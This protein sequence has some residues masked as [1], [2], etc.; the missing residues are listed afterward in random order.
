MGI[1]RSSVIYFKQWFRNNAWGVLLT[2]SI[3]TAGMAGAF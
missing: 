3:I 2:E 1:V